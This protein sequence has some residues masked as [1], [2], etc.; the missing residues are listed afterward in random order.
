MSKLPFAVSDA[1]RSKARERGPK[2]T[3]V[4]EPRSWGVAGKAA[5]VLLA[6]GATFAHGYSFGTGQQAE[7]ERLVASAS[8]LDERPVGSIPRVSVRPIRASWSRDLARCAERMTGGGH[9]TKSNGIVRVSFGGEVP[10]EDRLLI[11]QR[12]LACMAGGKPGKFCDGDYRRAFVEFARGPAWRAG[13]GRPLTGRIG[14]ETHSV[15]PAP[16]VRVALGTV[17]RTGVVQPGD[18]RTW[19][20]WSK[21]P[22]LVDEVARRTTVPGR[23][24]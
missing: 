18:F 10:A 19:L 5:V 1:Y 3:V 7:A 17:M 8:G 16:I 20:P 6:C 4:E 12:M 11:E 15:E 21:A 24:C 13:T 14:G 22:T 23:P 9:F 2:A